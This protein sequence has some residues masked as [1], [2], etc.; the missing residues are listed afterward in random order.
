MNSIEFEENDLNFFNQIGFT[1]FRKIE[2][3]ESGFDVRDKFRQ[4]LTPERDDFCQQNEHK[5]DKPIKEMKKQDE[6][7]TS[8]RNHDMNMISFRETLKKI[9]KPDQER[10]SVIDNNEVDKQCIARDDVGLGMSNRNEFAFK[11]N[12]TNSLSKRIESEKTRN[13]TESHFSLSAIMKIKQKFQILQN[14]PNTEQILL[15]LEVFE[16]PNYHS[17][18]FLKAKNM[19]LNVKGFKSEKTKLQELTSSQTNEKIQ[20][21]LANFNEP[22]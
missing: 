21:S 8:A 2:L 19:S 1:K 4:K 12:L 15:H 16:K 17:A 6:L 20:L 13:E 11:L 7:C 5:L 22:K 10:L 18:H 3:N 14:Q 9:K